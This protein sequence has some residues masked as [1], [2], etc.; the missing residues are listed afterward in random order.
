[1]D[2]FDL[3]EDEFENLVLWINN[4]PLDGEPVNLT[5]APAW[6]FAQ[7]R[8]VAEDEKPIDPSSLNPDE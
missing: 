5:Q 7:W 2:I 8:S 3:D 4:R 6:K 1:M